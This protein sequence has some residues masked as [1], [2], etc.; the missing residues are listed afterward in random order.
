MYDLAGLRDAVVAAATTFDA[1][2]LDRDGAMRAVALWTAVINAASAARAMAS[3][4]VAEC[5]TPPGTSDAATWLALTTGATVATARDT[6]RCGAEL[7]KQPATRAAATSGELSLQ[8]AAA[9]SDAVAADPAAERR[10]VDQAGR[11]SL[12][13]LR[14]ACQQVKAAADPFPAATERRIHARRALRRYRDGE[15]AEHLHVV[16]TRVELA[17]VDQAL[18]PV[19]DQ[20]LGQRRD[21]QP[22]EPYEAIAFDALVQLVGSGGPGITDRAR[23]PKLRYL[24]LLRVDLEAL[25]RGHVDSDDELCEITG[26]GPVPVATAREL[27]GE[28]LLK[29]VITKGSDVVHVTHLGRGV[30]TAQQLALLWQQPICTRQG[31]GRRQRLENDHRSEWARVRCTELR[32]LDPLCAADH[33]LKTRH[34]WALVEGAGKRPMVPP[35]HP[36][37][38]RDKSAARPR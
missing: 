21:A 24:T 11:D 37:H 16:G 18:A 5:G 27:L 29:L 32:N 26:L 7:Q 38:P 28:S 4:R 13:E 17:K 36:D 35:G 31:C 19:I 3:S 15:G 22:R 12:G 10:L 6:L 20:L 9:I 30:N 2:A 33:D 14:D 34:G 23:R 25:R 1:S 8:Q